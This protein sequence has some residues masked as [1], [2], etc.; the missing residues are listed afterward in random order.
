MTE[1]F[2]TTVADIFATMPKRFKPEEAKE[3]D[4]AI[5]YEATGEGG[6]KWKATIKHG[7]LKVETVE[8]ELT[9]C[10]T[11]IHTDAETFVGVT[12]GKIAALDAL[13]S[14]KLRV[15]GDPKFLMLLLPKIF[16]PYAAPA[17]KPDA[18]TARDIIATIAE[19]FRPEKAEGV[20]MTIGYD[21]AGE[22]GGKWTI[23]IRDGKCAVREGLADPLTVKMTMEAKTYAG[24]MVG[25]IEAVTAFTSGQ[26]KIEGDMAAAGATAKYF[27]KYVVPGATE[28]E[29]LISLRVIN[30][31][32]QRFAT[33]PVMG[34]WF[35][36]IRE[37]KFLANRCPKCGRTQIPPREICAWCRVRVHEFVEVGP[38]GVV[39]HFD[40]V[41]FASPDPLTGA[42]R[43]TPYAT[44][45]VVFDGA[46]EREAITLD[47]KQE[48]IPRLKEGAR[49]RPVWAEVTTGSYRDLIGVELDEE[50]GS[51]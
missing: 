19:R 14:Q 1:Y 8:G 42:V 44:A 26:V 30:S 35:A 12:L 33:G 38:K 46:T 45:Y 21:L 37:K 39:T 17:K 16:T 49:V 27:L 11:T 6:G 47:L 24:M 20:A 22:G 7:T 50:E 5:G 4:I 23:V 32:E 43:D 51:I 48:D 29:E 41:Y 25:T 3:V 28:A 36:G 40:I 9:G 2:G 10:K 31:I 34:R 13:S 18:V 15:A